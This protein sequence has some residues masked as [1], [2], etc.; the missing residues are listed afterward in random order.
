MSAE[1]REGETLEQGLAR[2]DALTGALERVGDVKA[3]EAARDLLAL[4]LDLHGRAFDRLS[5]IIAASSDG[6]A[7][8]ERIAED[9]DISA[10]LLLHGLHPKSAE[11][12]LQEVI[13]RMQPQWSARG[14][15]V[16]LVS[17][18]QAFAI[19]QLKRNGRAE[20]PERLRLEIENALIDAAPDLEDILIE[21][22]MT[23][24]CAEAAA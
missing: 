21:L 18:G 6:P 9:R 8:L 19:I 11:E 23:E 14:L 2:L 10:V 22:D 15:H 20:P 1:A 7:L 13:A 3:R 17:A 12:R 16:E 4:L 5:A 24:T